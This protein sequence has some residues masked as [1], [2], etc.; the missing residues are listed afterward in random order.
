[1]PFSSALFVGHYALDAIQNSFFLSRFICRRIAKQHIHN[2]IFAL[3]KRAFELRELVTLGLG[4][5]K[6]GTDESQVLGFQLIC[7]HLENLCVRVA[8]LIE[9]VVQYPLPIWLHI[10]RL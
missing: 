1:M 8:H 10:S 4:N 3:G 7:L 9:N 2:S 6:I 5:L